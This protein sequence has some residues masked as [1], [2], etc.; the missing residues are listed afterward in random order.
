[1][2][3]QRESQSAALSKLNEARQARG[4]VSDTFGSVHTRTRTPDWFVCV[5]DAWFANALNF[6][7]DV[8]IALDNK[9]TLARDVRRRAKSRL[10]WCT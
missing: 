2:R 9:V 3:T 7:I 10:V 8:V 5:R 1:M 6:D 4:G